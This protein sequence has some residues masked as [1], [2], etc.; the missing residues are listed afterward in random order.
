MIKASLEGYLGYFMTQN[1]REGAQLTIQTDCH[2][3]R[4]ILC[5][6]EGTRRLDRRGVRLNKLERNI[7]H[8]SIMKNQ[9]V[10]AL[11]CL[12]TLETKS[13]PFERTITEVKITSIDGIERD[14]EDL[15]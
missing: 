2:M 12:T 1:G 3:L 10:E 5:L 8:L 4:W 14:D 7:N 13:T 6:M 11:S 9:A 15:V